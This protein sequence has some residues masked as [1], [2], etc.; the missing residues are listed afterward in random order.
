MKNFKQ[1]LDESSGIQVISKNNYGEITFD[2]KG[3]RYTYQVDAAWFNHGTKFSRYMEF[4]PDKALN[5]AKKYGQYVAKNYG[6]T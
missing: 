3:T 2:V 5:L 4:A 1:W 6:P